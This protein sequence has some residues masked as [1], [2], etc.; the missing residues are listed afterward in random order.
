MYLVKLIF[1]ISKSQDINLTTIDKCFHNYKLSRTDAERIFSSC[2][3]LLS[4]N[5]LHQEPIG[6]MA[7]KYSKIAS[8]SYHFPTIIWGHQYPQFCKTSFA[9]SS[10]IDVCQIELQSNLSVSDI[11]VHKLDVNVSPRFIYYKKYFSDVMWLI[12]WR[13]Y[14]YFLPCIVLRS[15]IKQG[16][17]LI[18]F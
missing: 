13:L 4:Q 16:I 2:K 18:L 3:L 14:H 15:G 5:Y 9:S 1:C 6:I 11:S 8:V 7:L 10:S 12:A 17:V